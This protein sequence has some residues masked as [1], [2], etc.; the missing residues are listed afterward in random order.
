M[1]LSQEIKSTTGL[2]S[3]FEGHKR[4]KQM[5][6]SKDFCDAPIQ[7]GDLTFWIS[8][9]NN[10]C[11]SYNY[12]AIKSLIINLVSVQQELKNKV[13]FDRVYKQNTLC[14]FFQPK[15]GKCFQP[16]FF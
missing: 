16:D 9:K 3:H 5:V 13:K 12:F 15:Q 7:N 14:F 11:Q 2:T 8:T 4:T 6:H 10:G 1:G